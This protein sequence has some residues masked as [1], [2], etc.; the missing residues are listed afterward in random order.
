MLYRYAG[1]GYGSY[2]FRDGVPA[3]NDSIMVGSLTCDNVGNLYFSDLINIRRVDTNGLLC[4]VA[5]N[6]GIVGFSG[7]GGP[8][9]NAQLDG[10]RGIATDASG[11][12]YIADERN[13][14]IRKVSQP[15]CGYFYNETP[16]IKNVNNINVYPNP[17]FKQLTI[18]ATE[19]I[20]S[21]VIY[22]MFGQMVREFYCNTQKVEMDVSILPAGIYLIRIN[23]TEVRKFVKE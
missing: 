5:G 4:T 17:I 3:T 19:N 16:E 12:L 15:E 8:A 21:V 23:G 13:N 11:N 22:S 6:H 9:T 18:S 7:D 2:E 20:N 14:R 1:N 10:P